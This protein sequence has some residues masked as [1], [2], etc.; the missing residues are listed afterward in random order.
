MLLHSRYTLDCAF[1]VSPSHLLSEGSSLFETDLPKGRMV[2]HQHGTSMAGLTR[3][4]QICSSHRSMT[5]AQKLNTA[6]IRRELRQFGTYIEKDSMGFLD[7]KV[8]KDGFKLHQGW[9][10]LV[11]EADREWT[12]NNRS[13]SGSCDQWALNTWSFLPSSAAPVHQMPVMI[14]NSHKGVKSMVN[15]QGPIFDR[16]LLSKEVIRLHLE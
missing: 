1:H 4:L 2:W 13:F 14:L 10:R 16:I 15:H 11:F 3:C 5:W 7:A 6:G 12:Q 9:F 8:V